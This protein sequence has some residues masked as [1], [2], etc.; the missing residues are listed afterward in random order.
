MHAMVVS[1]TVTRKYNHSLWKRGG[2]EADGDRSLDAAVAVAAR[3]DSARVR[4]TAMVAELYA[5][6]C[7]LPVVNEHDGGRGVSVP[8]WAHTR[9]CSSCGAPLPTE[10]MLTGGFPDISQAS[11]KTL[12]DSGEVIVIQVKVELVSVATR[13]SR[14]GPVTVWTIGHSK[15]EMPSEESLS[16]RG[17][18]LP[19]S[20]VRRTV[21]AVMRI[22]E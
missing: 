2:V 10:A 15:E 8:R 21:P 13:A 4:L 11:A 16:R 18:F 3:V 17:P 9:T 1:L 7:R 14:S 22:D 6:L 20:R 5:R 19:A 12:A